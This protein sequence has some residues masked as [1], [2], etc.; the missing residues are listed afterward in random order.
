MRYLA[1]LSLA[2][3]LSLCLLASG[4]QRRPLCLPAGVKMT[5]VVLV[6]QT[7]AGNV[8][9]SGQPV[10]VRQKLSELKARCRRGKL[11]DARGKVIHFYRRTDCWGNPPFDASE[12]SRQQDDEIKK[13]GQRYTVVVLA[14]QD[15]GVPIP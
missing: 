1:L 12:R 3:V 8:G 2:P 6:E 15:F 10:R 7:G 4:Q 9:R 14:C 5:D 13:L 11:V